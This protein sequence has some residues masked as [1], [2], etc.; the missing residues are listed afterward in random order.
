[1]TPDQILIFMLPVCDFSLEESQFFSLEELDELWLERKVTK[2]KLPNFMK[3][4]N[5]D[6]LVDNVNNWIVMREES[7]KSINKRTKTNS[8]KVICTRCGK[9]DVTCEAWIN[10]NKI[11]T[12]EALDHF[13]DE[14]FYYGTCKICDDS[15][16]LT[17]VDEIRQRIDKELALFMEE[18]GREPQVAVCRVTFCN[19]NESMD[20]TK[21]RLS[22]GSNGDDEYFYYCNGA[23]ALKSLCEK[24]MEDFIITEIYRFEAE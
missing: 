16:E 2:Y 24:G 21:I 6:L 19:G 23:H 7:P 22:H 12:K 15:V 4:I 14:S 20:E 17:D 10:P 8:M 13:S 1:M 9:T 5:D 11:E 3:D 18:T